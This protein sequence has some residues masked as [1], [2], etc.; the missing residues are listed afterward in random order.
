[1]NKKGQ[2][3]SLNVIIIASIALLVLVVLVAYFM[4]SFDRFITGT[5]GTEYC[6]NTLRGS[7]GPVD[8]DGD[9]LPCVDT[10]KIGTCSKGE[11]YCCRSLG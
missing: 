7:C 4:G 2:G 10:D 9:P 6:E 11:G 8:G 1:M 5:S 3:I